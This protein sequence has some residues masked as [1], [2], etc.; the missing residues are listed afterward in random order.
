MICTH[1]MCG[2]TA[3]RIMAMPLNAETR[4]IIGEAVYVSPYCDEHADE[5]K[6]LGGFPASGPAL[7]DQARE[8]EGVRS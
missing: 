3:T 4:K 7:S 6:T 8:I 2:E 5:V 1:L